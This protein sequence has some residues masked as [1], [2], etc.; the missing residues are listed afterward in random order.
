M[1]PSLSGLRY[2]M[3]NHPWISSLSG[4]LANIVVLTTIILI[5]WTR[6]FSQDKQLLETSRETMEERTDME[7]LETIETLTDNFG[8]PRDKLGSVADGSKL[9]M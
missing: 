7:I 4:V 5:S 3:H 1:N 2:I 6:L 9:L 8:A